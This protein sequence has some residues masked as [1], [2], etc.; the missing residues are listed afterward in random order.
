MD[1]YRY[2][3]DSVQWVSDEGFYR[4]DRID[5]HPEEMNKEDFDVMFDAHMPLKFYLPERWN[6]LGTRALLYYMYGKKSPL[7]SWCD[8]YVEEF[9]AK[10]KN[11]VAFTNTTT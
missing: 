5:W 11:Y 4:L 10:V 9:Y 2:G 1:L 3:N 7:T 6:H 8:Q